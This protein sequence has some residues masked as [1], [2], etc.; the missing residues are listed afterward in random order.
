MSEVPIQE[1]ELLIFVMDGSTSMSSKDTFDSR[2]RAD[3]LYDLVKATLER[4]VKSER[5]PAYRCSFIY[6]SHDI[7]PIERDGQEYFRLDEALKLIEHPLKVTSGGQTSIAGALRK[8]F[9]I[10][11]KFHKDETLPQNKRIT[12]F[13]FTD[14]AENIENDNAVKNVANQIKSHPLSPILATVS[15][16]TSGEVNKDLLKEIA[17]ES[18]E[19]QRRHLK[20]AGVERHLEDPGKLYLDESV[21]GGITKEKAEALRNFVYVLSKTR[22]E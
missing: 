21:G 1:A 3:H 20:L 2:Q 5:K 10:I 16:G 15:F 17:S 13:L 14:G 9:E 6:F 19:R 12:V 22:K 11:D 7:F 8:A 4:L 18:S